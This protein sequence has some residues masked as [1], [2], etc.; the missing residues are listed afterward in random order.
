MYVNGISY[1][2]QDDLSMHCTLNVEDEYQLTLR[3][4]GMMKMSNYGREGKKGLTPYL[5]RGIGKYNSSEG[6][7]LNA[8]KQ[9]ED[10]KDHAYYHGG[11]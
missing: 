5:N 2:I 3:V 8:K 11:I 4:E 6:E 7:Y 1:V 9:E 10:G